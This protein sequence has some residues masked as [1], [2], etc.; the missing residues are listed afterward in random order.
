MKGCVGIHGPDDAKLVDYLA[1]FGENLADFDAALPVFLE[2]VGRGHQIAGN[3]SL[4]DDFGAGHGLAV[5]PLQFRFRVKSIEM[6]NPAVEEQE[7]DV[8]CFRR[9]VRCTQTLRGPGLQHV[10]Q[11]QRTESAT[12]ELK[13]FPS[14]DRSLHGMFSS[15]RNQLLSVTVPLSLPS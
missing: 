14:S 7:N 12:N 11:P 8:P 6:G 15:A 2:T 1:H 10:C 4:G 5:T 9:E 3:P 13:R